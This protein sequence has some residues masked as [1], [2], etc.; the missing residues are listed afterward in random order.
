MVGE[1]KRILILFDFETAII[2]CERS[3]DKINLDT[4]RWAIV[5]S[6]RSFHKINLDMMRFIWIRWIFSLFKKIYILF[7]D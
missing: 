6:E 2:E 5:E 1:G 3:F 7:S 4:L